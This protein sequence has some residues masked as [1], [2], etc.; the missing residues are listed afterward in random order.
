MLS[1]RYLRVSED[2]GEEELEVPLE[3]DGTLLLT[4]L[5][6]CFPQ[7]SGLKFRNERT[8][9]YRAV[10]LSKV[11]DEFKFQPPGVSDDGWD[12][13]KINYLCVFP[14]TTTATEQKVADDVSET[15]EKVS[16]AKPA[17]ESQSSATNQPKTVDL[18]ILNLSPQT[19]ELELRN[20]FETK[21]GPLLMSEIK[22]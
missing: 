9:C 14:K 19:T 10:K 18:I 7:S 17:I 4:T 6:S 20:Y 11:V 12:C 1:Q 13:E 2:F 15:S 5:Q 21:Y 16:S 3:D 8:G 22:R